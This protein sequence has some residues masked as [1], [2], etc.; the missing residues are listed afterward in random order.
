MKR[1]STKQNAN[2]L[3]NNNVCKVRSAKQRKAL[4]G[5]KTD[6]VNYHKLIQRQKIGRPY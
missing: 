1:M 2:K 5:I 6:M 4:Q 3:F